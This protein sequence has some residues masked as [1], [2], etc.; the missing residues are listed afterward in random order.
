MT[1]PFS[2]SLAAT[3][4][5]ARTGTIQTMR[6]TIRTP[7]FMP[8]GTAATV[9][10]MM[11]ESVAATGADIL[12]GNTYHLMLRPGAE[13]IARLGGLHHFMNWNKPILTDSGGFQVM[14]LADLRK[15]TENGVT[16]RSHI[17]GSRHELTPERSM[18]IQRLL[19]SDIVMAFDECP[20]LPASDE[21]VAA[22]MRLSMRWAARSRD[23]F[24]DRPGHALFGIMQGGVTR[25]LREESAEALKAIGFEGY[26]VGGLAVG[27]GQEA[28]FGV[29]DYAPGF[30]PADKP[31]YLMG[32]GKPDD[33]VGA[34][35]RGIDMMDCVLPSR[36]G[37]TGQAWTRRGQINIK[38]ARHAD[39]PRPLDEA[40]T[41]PACRNYS[42]AYLH[43]VFR[44]GEMISGMLL[45]WHNLHYYQ[46]LM[47]GLRGAIAEQTLSAFVA[48]F[49]AQRAE[50][51]IEPL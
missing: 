4:G 14:S 22:S 15:L 3:D 26:A 8:V 21:A 44:A 17:D 19:G 10:A 43:H 5:A 39:D 11:P 51:D 1:Q 45:T 16:F 33:I 36:S 34:V 29:L 38:N 42:R 13:R 7:A 6:G 32:V 2:F 31:R 50:G 40:C 23:A 25:E 47:S 12:L 9:K 18:E 35:E 37:R 30:L 41:C 46:E 28:M 24:G 48:D 49:H 27:E 20:A